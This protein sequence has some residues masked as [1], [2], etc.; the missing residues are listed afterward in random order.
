MSGP[1]VVVEYAPI[2]AEHGRSCDRMNRTEKDV[3]NVELR[4]AK[5]E[6]HIQ[7]LLLTLATWKGMVLGAIFISSVV[8][9]VITLLIKVFV[10]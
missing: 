4:L 1:P 9:T 2:C 3:A 5:A 10:G 8:S 7:E 6:Q